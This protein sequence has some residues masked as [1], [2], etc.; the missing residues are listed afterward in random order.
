MTFGRTFDISQ[1]YNE[2]VDKVTNEHEVKHID[3]SVLVAS[4]FGVPSRP[5]AVVDDSGYINATLSA[6]R[7]TWK[8]LLGF[9]VS[10]K[11][12]AGVT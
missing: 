11:I 3:T 6:D 9:D 7:A 8:M 10:R 4:F 2:A 5:E 1:N 12:T